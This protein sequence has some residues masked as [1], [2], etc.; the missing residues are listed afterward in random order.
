MGILEILM[1][2][3]LGC[4]IGFLL[5]YYTASLRRITESVQEIKEEVD[6]IDE[7][8]QAQKKIEKKKRQ[9][10]RHRKRPQDGEDGFVRN[11]IVMDVALIIVVALTVWASFASQ[12]ASNEL[13]RTQDQ[14]ARISICNQQ[15]L[16]RALNALTERSDYVNRQADANVSLQR[17]QGEFLSL[18]LKEPPPGDQERGAAL[19]KYVIALG[20]FYKASA[21]TDAKV[22]RTPYPTNQELSQCLAGPNS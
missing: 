8:V 14:L 1:W 17:A 4:F 18:L 7:Y 9:K 5:G 19:R 10:A 21:Q 15:F 2:L 20:Q 13:E 3:S 6:E 12:R 22:E 16:S 11:P